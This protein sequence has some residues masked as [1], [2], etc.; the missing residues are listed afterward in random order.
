M[1]RPPRFF[2]P[3]ALTPRKSLR[4]LGRWSS[5]LTC[6]KAGAPGVSPTDLEQQTHPSPKP[7]Q[8][9][10][11]CLVGQHDVPQGARGGCRT[12]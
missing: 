7:R 9:A 3:G 5:H 10:F 11:L 8:P 2:L 1:L 6:H 4:E 12:F